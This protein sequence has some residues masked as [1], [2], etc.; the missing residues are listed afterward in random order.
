MVLLE[1]GKYFGFI[2]TK[3]YSFEKLANLVHNQ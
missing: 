1:L 3:V 2:S